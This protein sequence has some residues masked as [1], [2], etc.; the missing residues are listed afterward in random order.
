MELSK[1]IQYLKILLKFRLVLIFNGSLK[2]K[3]CLCTFISEKKLGALI[4]AGAL[5]R[6]NM[7]INLKH[8]AEA[9]Q[10]ST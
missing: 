1:S 10:M 5:N 8:I 4:G 6:A 2:F 9:L 7:V 3:V